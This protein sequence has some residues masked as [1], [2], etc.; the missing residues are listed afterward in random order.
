MLS[1]QKLTDLLTAGPLRALNMPSGMV[2][3]PREA[4]GRVTCMQP[5]SLLVPPRFVELVVQNSSWDRLLLCFPF[6]RLL[7]H[8]SPPQKVAMAVPI[9]GMM[10][11][12]SP[13]HCCIPS[14]QHRDPHAAG[15]RHT[16]G[17]CIKRCQ[18]NGPQGELGRPTGT[19]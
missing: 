12:A 11:Q 13:I 14:T 9:L 3:S 6:L 1:S 2:A 7:I 19:T 8:F 18:A 4:S 10:S 16:A 15:P 17:S 5:Q